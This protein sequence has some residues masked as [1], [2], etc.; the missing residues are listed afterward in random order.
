MFALNKVLIELATYR[1]LAMSLKSYTKIGKI[2]QSFISV[3]REDTWE[4]DVKWMN[5]S[6]VLGNQWY[7]FAEDVG[8]E[9][10]DT[11]L[12]YKIPHSE[13]YIVNVCLFK[14]KE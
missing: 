10:G 11:L 9:V 13:P 14:G 12:F 3:L 8:L 7:G 2:V 5:N 6:C 1:D 4:I